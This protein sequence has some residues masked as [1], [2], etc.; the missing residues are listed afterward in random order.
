MSSQQRLLKAS[1]WR[2]KRFDKVTQ[3]NLRIPMQVAKEMG[4]C[5]ENVTFEFTY[6]PDPGYRLMTATEVRNDSN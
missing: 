2:Q 3:V 5:R 4:L 6:N 1:T